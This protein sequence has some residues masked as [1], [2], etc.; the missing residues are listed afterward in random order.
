MFRF[1]LI[2]DS[3]PTKMLGKLILGLLVISVLEINN[4]ITFSKLARK[5]S[6]FFSK[7]FDFEVSFHLLNFNVYF[8]HRHGTEWDNL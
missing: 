6:L 2:P 1:F 5:C 8:A 4:V 7:D 3:K